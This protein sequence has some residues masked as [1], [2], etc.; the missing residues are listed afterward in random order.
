MLKKVFFMLIPFIL[1]GCQATQ[2]SKQEAFPDVYNEKPVSILVVPAVNNTTA[3][4]APDLYA[5][6]VAAPLAEAGYYVLSVPYVKNFMQ[7]EGILDGTQAKNIPMPKYKEL[8]G[9][10]AVL[11]VTLNAWDTNYYVVGGNVTVSAKFEMK[12]TAT[13]RVIWQYDSTV[14]YN[15]SGNSGNLLADLIA[16]AIT[17]AV[18]DY[19]PIAHSVNHQ[20]IST[21]PVGKYHSRHEQDG[22]D[23]G[24]LASKAAP[25][26]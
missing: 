1:M 23:A 7:R 10:D 2:V 14:V 13:D 21:L 26:A 4:D 3:A 19:V 5:T 25:K 6:T 15:T 20:I 9:A 22:K 12:S 16:T 24:I 17:S 8:F 18:T 11:F